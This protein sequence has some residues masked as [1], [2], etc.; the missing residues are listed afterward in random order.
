MAK[1]RVDIMMAE[2]SCHIQEGIDKM[3]MEGEAIGIDTRPL[4]EM[5]SMLLIEKGTAMLCCANIIERKDSEKD[6]EK[7]IRKA[8][9]VLL[10]IYNEE[11]LHK[12]SAYAGIGAISARSIRCEQCNGGMSAYWNGTK[13]EFFCSKC[14]KNK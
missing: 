3:I 1:D 2:F 14:I 4:C 11:G 12:E 13:Y 6:V 9:R 7:K 5:T 8:V 10:R